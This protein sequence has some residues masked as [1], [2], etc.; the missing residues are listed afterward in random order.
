MNFFDLE[1]F[2]SKYWSIYLIG[3]RTHLK[4]LEAARQR[5]HLLGCYLVRDSRPELFE[6]MCRGEMEINILMEFIHLFQ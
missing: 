5:L 1:G 6:D 4:D 3:S 2:P